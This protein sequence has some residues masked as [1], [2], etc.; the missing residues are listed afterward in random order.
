MALWMIKRHIKA[1]DYATAACI[2][3]YI[4][5][6]FLA[7]GVSIKGKMNWRWMI[8]GQTFSDTLMT[9]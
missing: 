1:A 3:S 2:N 7:V 6:A 4:S 8:K 5:C 9:S